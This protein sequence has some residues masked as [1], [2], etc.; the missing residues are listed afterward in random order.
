MVWYSNGG[1]N[2][3]EKACLW[4]KMYGIQMVRQV[5]WLY[6]WIPDTLTV[7]Y[8]D[9]SGIHVLG[10]QMVTVLKNIWVGSPSGSVVV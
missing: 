9:E 8:S 5:T 3:T 1:E 6:I 7:W 2:P 10:I 4:S